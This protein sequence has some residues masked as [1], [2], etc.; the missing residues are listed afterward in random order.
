MAK[1]RAV[2]TKF[3]NDPWIREELN[4]LDRYLFLYFLTN[5]H[6][7]ISGVYELP[8]ATIAFE[9]G[10]DREELERTMIKRLRPKVIYHKSWVV[11]PNFPKHQNL[12]SPDVLK[13][14]EREFSSAPET[15]RK[16]AITRGWGDG[17][18]MVYTSPDVL[19]LTK[20]NLIADKSEMNMKSYNENE[21]YTDGLPE[22]DA[23]T[24]ES[25]SKKESKKTTP[26]MKQVFAIFVDNPDRV[27]WLKREVER[28]AAE[29]LFNEY[30]IEELTNRYAVAR[31]YR[32]E[33]L[34]P[35]IHSPSDFLKKMMK[36]EDFLKT[37]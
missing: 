9:T 28:M 35:K 27:M 25:L 10:I 29:T 20:P 5:E 18:G 37:L 4:P 13:G 32:N 33:T 12:K 17:L 15:V 21:H 16:E 7:N 6:A 24:R 26:E 14:I 11:I 30:G 36:M 23:E 3:W 34:C 1:Q 31:K 22:I 2:N 8:I 19:N